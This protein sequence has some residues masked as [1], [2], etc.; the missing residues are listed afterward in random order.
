MKRILLLKPWG[1]RKAG[2][3]VEVDDQRAAQLVKDKLGKEQTEQE[4]PKA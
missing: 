1:P 2:E 4:A 3:V